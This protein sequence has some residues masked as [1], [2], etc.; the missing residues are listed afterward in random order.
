MQSLF[1]HAYRLEVLAEH[2]LEY[3]TR[4][5]QLMVDKSNLASK[6]NLVQSTLAQLRLE[7]G[8]R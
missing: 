1:C 6:L 7:S 8:A 3:E 4:K 5:Q 2:R